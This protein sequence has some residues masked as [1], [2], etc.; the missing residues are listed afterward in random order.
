MI[1]RQPEATAQQVGCDNV[2]DVVSWFDGYLSAGDAFAGLERRVEILVSPA[3]RALVS[4]LWQRLDLMRERDMA[5]V[6]IFIGREG[7]G[8]AREHLDHH[9]R[10]FGRASA[11][12]G[13]RVADF[14]KAGGLQDQLYLSSLGTCVWDVQFGDFTIFENGAELGQAARLTFRMIW[15]ISSTLDR[16]GIPG[17]Q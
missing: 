4:A 17:L 12:Q 1:A 8:L 2:V 10:V 9:A 11:M 7:R 3:R 6:A 5:I 15:S 13:I 14:T 16:P